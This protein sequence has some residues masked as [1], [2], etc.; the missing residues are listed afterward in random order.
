MITR[1]VK[2]TFRRE[3]INEFRSIFDTRK[4]QIASFDGCKNVQLLQDIRDER[5]FFTISTW[6]TEAH[7]NSYRDSEFFGNTWNT[8]KQ[9]FDEKPQAWTTR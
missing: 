1:I 8:V 5:I 3:T 7:L 4:A 2:M 9:L 6:D